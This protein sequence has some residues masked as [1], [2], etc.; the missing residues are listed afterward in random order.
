[1]LGACLACVQVEFDDGMAYDPDAGGGE[2]ASW[3]DDDSPF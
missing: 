2:V 3:D 1:M